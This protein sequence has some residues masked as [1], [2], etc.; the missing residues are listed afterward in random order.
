MTGIHAVTHKRCELTVFTEVWSL[1]YLYESQ[2]SNSKVLTIRAELQIEH[3]IF[4]IKV[5]Q[6]SSRDK[7]YQDR[8]AVLVDR[9]H[10]IALFIECNTNNVLSVFICKSKRLIID[11]VETRDAISD[12]AQELRSIFGEKKITLTVNSTE[13]VRELECRFH[14]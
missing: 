3:C 2:T 12:R 7:I 1:P 4:K 11:Q 10:Q 14:D 9:E 6:D 13:Q 5:V 8:A